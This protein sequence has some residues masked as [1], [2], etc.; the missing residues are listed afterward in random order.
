[1]IATMHELPIR[2][3][4]LEASLHAAMLRLRVHPPQLDFVRPIADSLAD[5]AVCYDSEPMAI[6]RGDTPI[7]FYRIERHPRSIADRDFEAGTLGL[8]SFFIDA[9]VQGQGFG[10]R[11]LAA[12]F[13]DLAQRHP[14]TRLLVLTVNCSNPAALALYKRAGFEDSGGLYHGGRSG[15]QLLMLR[16]L[17]V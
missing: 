14:Q 10:T 17:P 6:L 13:A 3:A 1:M 16:R 8:R 11:A 7:G 9:D 15:P 12:V 2:V 4:P 5:A